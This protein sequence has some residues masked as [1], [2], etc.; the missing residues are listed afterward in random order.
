MREEMNWQWKHI[1]SE[2]ERDRERER[3]RDCTSGSV[4][5][6]YGGRE[7]NVWEWQILKHSVY[8]WR[9]QCTVSCWIIRKHGNRER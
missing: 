9:K 3:T 8:V 5:E 1:K 6:D 4:W 7:R 2:R